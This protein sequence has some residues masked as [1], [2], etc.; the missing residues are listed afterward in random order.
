MAKRKKNKSPKGNQ[1]FQT[2]E[3]SQ[4]LPKGNNPQNGNTENESF[5]YKWNGYYWT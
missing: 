3:N 2:G 5:P 4:Q 1:N